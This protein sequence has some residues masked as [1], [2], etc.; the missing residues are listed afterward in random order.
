ML[1][2][3]AFASLSLAPAA[4]RAQALPAAA[5]SVA[6][7]R[8]FVKWVMTAQGD[9][10]WAHAGASLREGMKSAAGV[11]EMAARIATRFG[12]D[13]GTVAEVQFDEGELKVYIV[14]MNFSLAPEAGAWVV[15]Y[16]P[17]TKMV[18][19][20]SFTSLTNVKTRY[21]NAKLP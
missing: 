13:K 6:F 18:E 21:P 4:L 20:S 15:A 16:S 17:T 10:A 3:G 1:V 8:Q 2:A 14:G 7:P 12:E 9:S 11:N 5:D 19:R